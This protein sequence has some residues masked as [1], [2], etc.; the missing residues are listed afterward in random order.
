M[1]KNIIICSFLFSIM[2]IFA[3]TSCKSTKIE[4]ASYSPTGVVSVYGNSSLPWYVNPRDMTSDTDNEGGGMLSGLV[5]RALGAND[6]EIQTVNSR[7]DNAADM[8][9][10]MVQEKLGMQVVEHSKIEETPMYKANGI[11]FLTN[12]GDN[13]AA[14]GYKPIE[15]A[16]SKFNKTVSKQSGV[17]SL[18]YVNFIF[19]KEKSFSGIVNQVVSARTRMTV[20]IYDDKGRNIWNKQYSAASSNSVPYQ[21]AKWDKEE[22][23]TFYPEVVENVINQFIK[24]FSNKN[25]SDVSV[26]ETTEESVVGATQEQAE[27]VTTNEEA[28]PI[29]IPDSVKKNSHETDSNITD[30][31]VENEA[32]VVVTQ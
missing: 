26:I 6:P 22:L 7:I 20:K 17:K 16:G 9:S 8:F 11:N 24:D 2:F 12:V 30:D 1:K 25:E 14:E 10:K 18:M 27:S 29:A 28:T 19:Y 3:L 23:C 13:V 31:N 21:S 5:N 15:S 32:E 4:P